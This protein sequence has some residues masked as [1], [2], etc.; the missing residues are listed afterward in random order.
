MF[1][2]C[3]ALVAAPLFVSERGG[4]TMNGVTIEAT[5]SV[6]LVGNVYEPEGEPGDKRLERGG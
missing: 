5:D 2:S 4:A 6:N 1:H 3:G